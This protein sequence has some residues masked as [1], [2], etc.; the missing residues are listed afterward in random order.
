MEKATE[1]KWHKLIRLN[2][3]D[4]IEMNQQELLSLVIKCINF[5]AKKHQN[6]RRKDVAQTPYINHPIGSIT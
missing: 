5:A 1:N 2:N 4:G 6:Q 3:E